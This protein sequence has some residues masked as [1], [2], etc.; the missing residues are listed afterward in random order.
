MAILEL[1]NRQ[2]FTRVADLQTATGLPAPTIVRILETLSALGYIEQVGRMVGYR[3]TEK[4]RD[5]SAGFTG[6]SE[7][8]SRARDALLNVTSDLG[9]PAALAT[10]DGTTMV[11][12]LSTIPESPFS[13]AANTLNKRLD[14]L[15]RAH[16]RA[17]LAFCQSDERRCLYRRLCEVELSRL[18][19]DELAARMEPILRQARH[20]GYAERAH[21]IDPQTS[22][23]AV[24]VVDDGHI[25]ATLGVTFFSG[26]Q[27]SRP[28]LAK[29]LT[30]A[31]G[32]IVK[33]QD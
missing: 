19:V 27:P 33:I 11:V 5:L 31:A 29:R 24:P 18:T 13:H 28:A 14:L 17:Y 15:T 22:T 6:L 9:W 2:P 12:R 7:I 1:L 23:L 25:V 16:G 32:H 8:F 3:L 21:E 26:S 4:V 10:L 20:L 30:A